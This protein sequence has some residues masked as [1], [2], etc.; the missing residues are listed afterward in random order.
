MEL[1]PGILGSQNAMNAVDGATIERRIR[2]NQPD[3][4]NARC[5]VSRAPDQRKDFSPFMRQPATPS[6]SN[7]ISPQ[8]EPTA[9]FARRR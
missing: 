4:E 3:D 9:I 2:I 7:A 6:T 5:K 1:Q 8:Q